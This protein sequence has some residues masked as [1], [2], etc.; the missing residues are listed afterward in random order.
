[1][2][3]NARQRF[4]GKCSDCNRMFDEMFRGSPDGLCND[5]SDQRYINWRCRCGSYAVAE[6]SSEP[7]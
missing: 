2:M 6:Q 4:T 5:V 3:D 1:M 7:P